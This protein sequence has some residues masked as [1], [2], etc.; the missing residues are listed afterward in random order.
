MKNKLIYIVSGLI[1]AA[2]ITLVGLITLWSVYPYKPL[3][4]KSISVMT[5][6]V[7]RG[8][9][10]IYELDYCKTGNHQVQI[11]RRF[12]DGVVYSV[13]EIYTINPKGCKV[14][15][16][17]LLIPESLPSGEYRLEI[18]YSYKVNPI[19]TV[20]V[21]AITGVFLIK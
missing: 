3:K 10:F 7:S 8:E 19:R 18:N 9:V 17:G 13:P 6:E 4:I 5:R 11:S 12:V 20:T 16:I 2:A 1:I 15:N 21:S 14:S